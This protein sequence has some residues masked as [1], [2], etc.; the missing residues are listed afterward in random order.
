MAIRPASR[1]L[2]LLT[3]RPKSPHEDASD[4]RCRLHRHIDRL[5]PARLRDEIV[6]VDDVNP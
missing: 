2:F 1:R 4:W 3:E 5:A 6:G